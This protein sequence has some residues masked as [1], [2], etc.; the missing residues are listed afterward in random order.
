MKP[1]ELMLSGGRSCPCS[2]RRARWISANG[3]KR[4][5]SPPMIAS[6][7]GRPSTP[8]RYADSGVP[9]TATQTGSGSWTGRG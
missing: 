5:G 7:I 2:P 6:A 1:W 8:A 9:P 4:A 3:A